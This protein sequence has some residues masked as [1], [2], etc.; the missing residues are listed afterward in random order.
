MLIL[1]GSSIGMM[2][3]YTLDY[4]SPL[5][6]RRTASIKL[7][8]IKFKDLKEFFPKAN[9]EELMNIYGFADGIPF[10]LIKIDKQFFNW[11]DKEIKKETSF[12]RD[13]IDFLMRYEFEDVSTYK[14]ILKA[15]AFGFHYLVEDDYKKMELEFPVYDA[16]Y[17]Y[18]KNKVTKK[19]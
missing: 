9:F 17:E 11:L 15:I 4:K 1:S 3:K 5:Y 14:L 16:L 18:C 12:L 8:G 7:K 13:E 6:G 10:Y 2:E 19:E